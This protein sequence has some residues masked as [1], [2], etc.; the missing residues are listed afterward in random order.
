MGIFETQRRKMGKA[1]TGAKSLKKQKHLAYL[2]TSK[3]R[4]GE[5]NK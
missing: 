1:K 5:V 4:A 2:A 3:Q